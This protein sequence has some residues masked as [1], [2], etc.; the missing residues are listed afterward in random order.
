[1][2]SS[3]PEE[4]KKNDSPIESDGEICVSYKYLTHI[5]KPEIVVQNKD[6]ISNNNSTKI[7]CK[8]QCF[9]K[10]GNEKNTWSSVSKVILGQFDTDSCKD[11][12]IL[13]SDE[14]SLRS[15]MIQDDMSYNL[16]VTGP[17]ESQA[18]PYKICNNKFEKSEQN[19]YGS[20]YAILKS[21]LIPIKRSFVLKD[22]ECTRTSPT[23][24]YFQLY[25]SRS[26]SSV[27][28]SLS[29]KKSK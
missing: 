11:K 27:M 9:G 10:I 2:N 24:Q 23:V 5:K 20:K 3:L 7:K 12:P 19:S 26:N 17:S 29:A 8:Y 14:Q 16:S 18:K 25:A 1:M 6:E 4:S 15:T 22:G 13:I 28:S 21:E